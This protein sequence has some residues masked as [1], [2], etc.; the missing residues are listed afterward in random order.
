MARGVGMDASLK[1]GQFRK[2]GFKFAFGIN[3]KGKAF[4][5][6]SQSK[7]LSNSNDVRFPF[8]LHV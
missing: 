1:A 4:G 2:S 6:I 8:L 5:I 7:K 3:K